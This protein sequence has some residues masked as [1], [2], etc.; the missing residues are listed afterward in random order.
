M[1]F[2]MDDYLKGKS[3]FPGSLYRERC[4][5]CGAE[6]F[7]WCQ[8]ENG[9]CM[10]KPHAARRGAERAGPPREGFHKRGNR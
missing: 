1:Q 4:P 6:P 8:T 9:K 2:P 7:C 3:D 10:Y 5:T